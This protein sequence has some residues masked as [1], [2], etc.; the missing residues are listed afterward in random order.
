M[1]VSMINPSDVHSISE[2]KRNTPAYLKRLKRTG[3]PEVLTTNGESAVVVQDSKAYERQMLELEQRRLEV[4]MLEGLAGEA[5]PTTPDELRSRLRSH[6]VA[7][8]RA[9][10]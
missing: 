5:R 7:I 1:I 3:R 4:L 8:R 2:F 6:A 9:G 10:K